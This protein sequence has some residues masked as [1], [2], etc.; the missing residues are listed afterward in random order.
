MFLAICVTV[1]SS[2]GIVLSTIITPIMLLLTGGLLKLALKLGAAPARA[3]IAAIRDFTVR[4]TSALHISLNGDSSLWEVAASAFGTGGLALLGIAV[5]TLIVGA[6]VWRGLRGLFLRASAVDLIEQCGA[7]PARAD[8]LEE[9][10]LVNIVDEVAIGSGVPSPKLFLIDS[11][12]INAT[13]FG[14]TP[15]DAVLLVTR[16]LLDKLDRDETQAI[17]ARLTIGLAVG[18]LYIASGIMA[19]FHTYGLFL[20]LLSLPVR[21]AAWKALRRLVSLIVTSRPRTEAVASACALLEDNAELDRMP[22][23]DLNKS[24]LLA[25]LLFPWVLI[26]FIVLLYKLLMYVWSFFLLS[27]PLG[28]LWRNRDLWSDAQT[29]KLTRAPDV[30]ARALQKVG[31]IRTPA[32]AEAYFWLHVG[33]PMFGTAKLTASQR[34]TLNAMDGY[35]HWSRAAANPGKAVLAGIGLAIVFGLYFFLTASIMAGVLGLGLPLVAV[36]I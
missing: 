9:R 36:L 33:K 14:R 27:P 20:T 1:A 32:G 19:A 31:G 11:P 3:G 29:V 24:G 23:I 12:A 25:V 30:F 10:T 21:L 35:L 26:F 22:N 16:G 7:R 34:L 2:L 5:P 8:D 15:E 18:D 6:V 4:S 13:I 28:A 17:I